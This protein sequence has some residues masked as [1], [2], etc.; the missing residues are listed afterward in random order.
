M[1]SPECQQRTI[2][3]TP[4][5][6]YNRQ[7]VKGANAKGQNQYSQCFCRVGVACLLRQSANGSELCP[8]R[9]GG[10]KTHLLLLATQR[11]HF[12]CLPFLH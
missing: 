3:E 2:I 5:L 9:R 4:R 7:D 1:T 8:R 11:Q 12:F 6:K 10:I